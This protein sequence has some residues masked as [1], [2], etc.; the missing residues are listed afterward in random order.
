LKLVERALRF[1]THPVILLDKNLKDSKERPGL[2]ESSEM[3]GE[4]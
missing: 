3:K 2:G 4:R 1:G